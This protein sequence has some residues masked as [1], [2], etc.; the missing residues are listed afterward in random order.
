MRISSLTDQGGREYQEDRIR[1]FE[2][3]GRLVVVVADGHGGEG[4]ADYLVK[5]MP[6][7]F[8]QVSF[9]SLEGPSYARHFFEL[10]VRLDE[11]IA[12]SVTPCA[13]VGSTLTITCIGKDQ[14]VSANCGDSMAMVVGHEKVGREKV[15]RDSERGKT[16]SRLISV[17]HKAGSEVEAIE[18]RGGHVFTIDM[19]RVMGSLNLSRSMG[20]FALKPFIIPCPHVAKL[21]AAEVSFVFVATDGVWD[22]FSEEEI[23]KLLVAYEKRDDENILKMILS[24]SRARGSTDNIAMVLVRI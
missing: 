11:S 18:R 24:L 20:D 7:V 15:G 16:W 3:A 19:P 4:V 8:E 13:Q 21:P 2:V 1:V 22:V 17:E 23:G 12:R 14:I 5:E 10:F 9:E 6:T